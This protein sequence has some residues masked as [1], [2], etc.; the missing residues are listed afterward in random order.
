VTP[1]AFVVITLAVSRTTRLVTTDDVFEPLRKRLSQR[2]RFRASP[3]LPLARARRHVPWYVALVNCDWCV[4]F[5]LGA[6]AALIAKTTGLA[7]TWVWAGWCWPGCAA[8][9]GL[10]LQWQ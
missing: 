1:L 3:Q 4:S 10:V 8:G 6:V 9:A 5:W 7:E 2:V